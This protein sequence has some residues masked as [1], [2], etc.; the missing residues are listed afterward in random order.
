MNLNEKLNEKLNKLKQGLFFSPKYFFK[1]VLK[2]SLVGASI[3]GLNYFSEKAGYSLGEVM[4]SRLALNIG[5]LYLLGDYMSFPSDR[6]WKNELKELIPKEKISKKS[7][8]LNSLVKSLLL[9]SYSSSGLISNLNK[10]INLT[11]D[12]FY[13]NPEIAITLIPFFLST[14]VVVRATYNLFERIPFKH[15]TKGNNFKKFTNGLKNILILEDEESLKN[16]LNNKPDTLFF[17]AIDHLLLGKKLKSEDNTLDIIFKNYF[18]KQK[19]PDFSLTQAERFQFISAKYYVDDFTVFVSLSES[20]LKEKTELQDYYYNKLI[21]EENLSL[22]KQTLL[23]WYAYITDK[24]ESKKLLTNLSKNASSSNEFRKKVY[25]KASSEIK[26]LEFKVGHHSIESI[27]LFK[28][29]S[30]NS[31]KFKDEFLLSSA[32]EKVAKKKPYYLKIP[33]FNYTNDGIIQSF[34]TIHP[35]AKTVYEQIGTKTLKELEI[36]LPILLNLRTDLAKEYSLQK[37][38]TLKVVN[39]YESVSENPLLKTKEYKEQLKIAMSILSDGSQNAM[40]AGIDLHTENILEKIKLYGKV[41]HENNGILPADLDYINVNHYNFDKI[42]F[43]DLMH[44]MHLSFDI[45]QQEFQGSIREIASRHAAGLIYRL[46]RFSN[47]WTKSN[48]ER[49]K[50]LKPYFN[51]TFRTLDY[52]QK[53]GLL[54]EKSYFRSFQ[55]NKSAL[56]SKIILI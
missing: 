35:Q 19:K 54:L 11:L 6:Q 38:V 17:P 30:A 1:S 53:E 10:K 3:L 55:K 12:H 34:S 25:K 15:I 36:Q 5:F 14:Y 21:Q 50:R 51:H 45:Y 40:Q 27:L 49:N 41:D 46:E 28:E 24:K 26:S 33:L 37:D 4:N 29:A 22:S 31:T 48:P 43:S 39:L 8:S 42:S 44:L 23:A 52:L 7:F 20:T 32:Y 47:S 16:Y 9:I 56:E 18:L 13:H 2:S